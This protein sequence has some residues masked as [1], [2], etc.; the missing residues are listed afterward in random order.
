LDK[1][2]ILTNKICVPILALFSCLLW[3]SAFP[4][5]K[6]GYKMLHI[7]SKD[8][9][10]QITFA[11]F[12]FFIASLMVIVFATIF[13]RDEMKVAK[14]KWLSIFIIGI[15]QT[16]VQYIFFYVGLSNT[17]G[18]K[19]SIIAS[20]TAFFTILIAHFIYKDDKITL[21]KGLGIII[22]F[23][24]I[25]ILNIKG[26]SLEGNVNFFGEGFLIFSC[27]SSAVASVMIKE[28]SKKISPVILTGYQIF[29]G[30]I[31]LI[32]IG[33]SKGYQ[34][35]NFGIGSFMLLIYMAF[36]SAAAF[37][38]WA[39]ITKYNKIGKISVYNFTIPI[40]GTVLSGIFLNEKIF[41]IF[42]VL[43]LV[44]VT[45]GIIIVNMKKSN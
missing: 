27:I 32:I 26:L 2:K 11:G 21:N 38:I 3:G 24:G 10:K 41:T 29:I 4:C 31:V 28:A 37:S 42:N 44:M 39:V 12:R 9:Y 35:L 45:T 18:V 6:I 13:K 15:F 43:A 8:V 17:T 14:N 33:F 36:I 23:L 22:G 19:G 1:E 20:T 40:F 25:I 34:K 30:S 7:N 5:I 16:T